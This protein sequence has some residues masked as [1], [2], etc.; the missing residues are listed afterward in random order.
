[1]KGNSIALAIDD[2]RAKAKRSDRMLRFNDFAAIRDYRR[3]RV[4]TILLFV[5]LQQSNLSNAA[6]ARRSTYTTSRDL[7][8][9]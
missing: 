5:T 3:N 7:V 9:P 8:D 4:K 1:M 6:V 2:D